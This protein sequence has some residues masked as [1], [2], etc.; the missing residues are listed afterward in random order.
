MKIF[1]MNKWGQVPVSPHVENEGMDESD[2]RWSVRLPFIICIMAVIA[3]V[4]FLK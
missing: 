2:A 3:L 1:K 4:F